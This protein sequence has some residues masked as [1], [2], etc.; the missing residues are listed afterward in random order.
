MPDPGRAR[1]CWRRTVAA[2]LVLLAQAAAPA[3]RANDDTIRVEQ[4]Q[5]L[6]DIAEA[7]LGDPDLWAEIL[8]ANGLT[9][10]AEIRPGMELIVPAAEIAAADRAL[11]QALAAIQRATEGGA[12]LFAPGQI[13]R[14]I[15]RYEDATVRRK[16]KDWAGAAKAAGE[17][18]L[19]ANEALE[20]AAIGR[21]AAAEARLTDREGSVEGRTPQELV[22]TDRQRDAVLIEE[23]KLRTLSRSSAQITFRDDS[24]LRLNA[25]S[26]AVIRRMRSDL[27]SRTEEAKVSLVE[28]D[29]YALLS[30]KTGRKTFELQVPEVQTE[31]ESRSFWVRHD[32]SGSKFANYD[33]GLLRVAAKGAEV[34]LGRNE[35]TLVRSGEQPGDKVG[36]RAAAVLVAPADN[37]E[38]VAAEVDL[39]WEPVEDAA[40]YWLELAHDQGFQRMEIS[41]WGLKDTGFSTGELALGTYY[42]RIAALDKFGLPGERGAAW[43]FHVR[44]DQTPPFLALAEPPENAVVRHSPLVVAGQTEPGARMLL[45]GQTLPVDDEGRFRIELPVMPGAGELAFQATDK[46]GNVT[47]RRRAYRHVPDEA[48]ILRFD[49]DLPRLSPGRF[50]TRGEVISLTGITHAGAR[51]LLSTAKEPLRET[52]YAGLDGRF[53]L[54]VPVDGGTTDYSLEVVQRSGRATRERFSVS[55]DREPPEVSLDL[56]PPA[57]TSVEWLPIRGKA[58]GAASL[59]LNGRPVRLIGDQFD[60]TVTLVPGSNMVTL[61]ATDLVGNARLERFEVR[62]DQQPPELT[63][64]TVT[65]LQVRKGEPVRVEVKARDASGLRLAA[66]FKLRVAGIDY[67]DFLELRGDSGSYAATLRLPQNAAGPVRLRE[68]EIEDYAGNKARF[69]LDE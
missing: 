1:P 49:D 38:T 48:A 37:A 59:T 69:V 11:A 63:G 20:L 21:D 10:P 13:E 54:N 39:R 30:G 55:V 15:A 6:R 61:E 40:G 18:R 56:P 41:R 16:A 7:H 12:R 62:L 33:D 27:L 51:L 43:R 28:G 57:I 47:R 52:A 60:E 31:V 44:I 25:N 14:G 9:S 36:L 50:V 5:S 46:A 23:E 58:K 29:F 17:A 68:V 67:G 45:N 32:D 35:A 19:A 53:T 66:P 26:Q 42:W 8:R 2:L 4:G 3:L 64:Y 65:P 22:W 34:A 24:R